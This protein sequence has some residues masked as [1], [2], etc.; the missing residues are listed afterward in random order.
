MSETQDNK[1]QQLFVFAYEIDGRE[2]V[3]VA[4]TVRGD[5]PMITVS[6]K[7]KEAMKP[8]AQATANKLHKTIRIIRFTDREDLEEIEEKLVKPV[9]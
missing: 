7:M 9:V 8:L 6:E 2:R 4:P 5:L 1:I 3:V